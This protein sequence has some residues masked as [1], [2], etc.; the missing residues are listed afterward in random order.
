MLLARTVLWRPAVSLPVQLPEEINCERAGKTDKA[1]DGRRRFYAGAMHAALLSFRAHGRGECAP[2]PSESMAPAISLVSRARLI[3]PQARQAKT[4]NS[5]AITTPGKTMSPN[6]VWELKLLMPYIRISTATIG[7]VPTARKAVRAHKRNQQKPQGKA[8]PQGGARQTHGAIDAQVLP[9]A[10][11]K[12]SAGEQGNHQHDIRQQGPSS[13]GRSRRQVPPAAPQV[14][15]RSAF[16]SC[17]LS[18]NNLP[19]CCECSISSI[20]NDKM[21]IK[22]LFI[23]LF[24]S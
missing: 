22:Y 23:M 19:H 14:S 8:A 1:A 15:G 4:V 9:F 24:H 6:A 20:S 3:F 2:L 11:H 5:K 17:P 16:S 12:L 7:S 10:L 21:H 18:L 13:R